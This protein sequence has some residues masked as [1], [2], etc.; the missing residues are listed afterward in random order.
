M[1]QYKGLDRN[2]E[3][4]LNRLKNIWEINCDTILNSLKE[5]MNISIKNK[6]KIILNNFNK[7]IN[8][9]NKNNYYKNI[10]TILDLD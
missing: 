2:I 7:I 1:I 5:V 9:H 4:E 6:E 10:N 3:H 8:I